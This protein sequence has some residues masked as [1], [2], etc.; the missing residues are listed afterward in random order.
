MKNITIVS[1]KE[2]INRNTPNKIRESA[3]TSNSKNKIN[4]NNEIKKRSELI[5]LKN[6]LNNYKNQNLILSQ[7][8]QYL[9][10]LLLF[11]QNKCN[12]LQKNFNNK[13]NLLTNNKTF[14]FNV[15]DKILLSFHSLINNLLDIL[16]IFIFDDS[17]KKVENSFADELINDIKYK[18]INKFKFLEKNNYEWLDGLSNEINRIKNWNESYDFEI[19]HN[20]EKYR[21]S[22]QENIY[23]QKGKYHYHINLSQG[24]NRSINEKFKTTKETNSLDDI[25]LVKHNNSLT[26]IKNYNNTEIKIKNFQYKTYLIKKPNNFNKSLNKESKK[27]IYDYYND[28]EFNNLTLKN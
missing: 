24:E 19:Y 1:N 14:D 20:Q 18:L 9:K 7:R 3:R 10:K 11:N 16:E 27:K 5:L 12:I 22:S 26:E 6:E 23:K 8:N 15:L 17:F 4:N 13:I 21:A 28:E 25:S 2:N